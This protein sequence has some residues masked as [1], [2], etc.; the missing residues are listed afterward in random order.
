MFITSEY[1]KV[2]NP[3]L[4][5]DHSGWAHFE[6][7]LNAPW[8]F[9]KIKV[10]SDA[11]SFFKNVFFNNINQVID[12]LFETNIELKEVYLVTP[13]YVNKSGSWKMDK[14]IK[15]FKS[16]NHDSIGKNLAYKIVS[17]DNSEFVVDHF[18]FNKDEEYF[19]EELKVFE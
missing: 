4:Q 15:L 16:T 6:L 18:H 12:L 11:D 17:Y 5:D 7:L 8:Y 19:F 10:N 14:V 1:A 2:E 13:N 3:L 9:C